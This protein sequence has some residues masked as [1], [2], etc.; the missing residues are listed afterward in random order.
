MPFAPGVL[1]SACVVGVGLSAPRP[2]TW[3]TRAGR[4][5]LGGLAGWALVS[6]IR[7][8]LPGAGATRTSK[9]RALAASDASDLIRMD[10][11]KG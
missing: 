1:V 7:A 10:S 4:L 5:I 9:A 3:L 2:G 8:V 6:I 11:D